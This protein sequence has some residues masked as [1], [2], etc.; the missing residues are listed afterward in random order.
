MR[1]LCPFGAASNESDRLGRAFVNSAVQSVCAEEE[2]RQR[3]RAH[4][5]EQFYYERF[6]DK[7]N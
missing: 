6:W 3:F 1:R 2:L 7:L 5:Q 4:P